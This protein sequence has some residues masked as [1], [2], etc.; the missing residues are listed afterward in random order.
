MDKK[1]ILSRISS[2][3]EKINN[4]RKLIHQLELENVGFE[5]ELEEC[6]K[7]V[8]NFNLNE[9]QQDA[10]NEIKNNSIIIACPGSGKTHTL[11]AKV[12]HLVV[13]HQVD[14]QQIV[15]VT[16]TKKAAQEMTSRLSKYLGKQQLFHSGTIHGLAYRMIQKYDKINYTIIDESESHKALRNC[17]SKDSSNEA[18]KII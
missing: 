18:E 11:V 16:F 7:S 15:L 1:L 13:D 8:T 17:I 14:P 3:N 10:V 2:N 9:A 4:Y 12:V 6:K 5:K